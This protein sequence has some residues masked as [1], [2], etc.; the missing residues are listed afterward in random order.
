LKVG[1]EEKKEKNRKEKELL[2]ESSRSRGKGSQYIIL[3]QLSILLLHSY[4]FLALRGEETIV[5][6]KLV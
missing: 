1:S 6:I 2:E 5:N 4:S 3:E